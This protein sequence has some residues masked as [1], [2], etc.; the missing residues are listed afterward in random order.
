MFSRSLVYFAKFG[1]ALRGKAQKSLGTTDCADVMN[2]SPSQ[3]HEDC[4]LAELEKASLS[5]L[6]LC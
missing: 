4:D 3:G 1:G 6:P 5:W 2:K